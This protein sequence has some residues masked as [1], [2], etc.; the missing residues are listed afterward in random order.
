MRGSFLGLAD[1]F[2]IQEVTIH[3]VSSKGKEY[4]WVYLP[5]VV[6][7]MLKLKR[8]DKFKLFVDSEGNIILKG[9]KE[10]RS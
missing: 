4:L 10:V 1:E 3:R 7:N 2:Y 5:K 8:G 9:S 6:T